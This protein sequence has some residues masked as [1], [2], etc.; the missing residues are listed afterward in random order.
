[1]RSLVCLGLLLGAGLTVRAGNY[2][3]ILS[4]L[5][6]EQEYE[7][8]FAGW[9]SD[10]GKLLQ[11]EPGA[12]VETLAGKDAIKANIE[13]KLRALAGQ[14]KPGDN[15]AVFLIGHGSYDLDYK[16]NIPGVDIT[17][18]ELA[19]LLD[20]IPANQCVVNMTSASGG[21]IAALQKP[22]RVVITATK[23]GTEKNATV[24]AR[25]FIEALRD[26]AAD[27]DKNE[28]ISALE[29][30]RYAEQKTA[31]FFEDQ[32]RLA[33]EH[34]LIE[35]TG[36]GEGVKAPSVEKGEGIIANR[37][38]LLHLGAVATFVNNPE[39]QKLLKRKEEL[40]AQ[41]DELK[42]RKASMDLNDYRRQLQALLVELAKT[43][44]ELDQ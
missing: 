17:A 42:Y 25:Y 15:L 22:K 30:F 5:G 19:G 32:K 4:G 34:A 12:K 40:E 14:A 10:L 29:A 8:R 21:S 16:F 33:T 31:K 35:D 43:Q 3:L 38:N 9:A 11:N 7:Q 36:N 44:T 18:A 39:K 37:F 20:K 1:M 2:Y 6:G 28:A 13:A 23:T 26:P 24:F 27:A 41:I